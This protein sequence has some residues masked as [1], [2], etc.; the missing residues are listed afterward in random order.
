MYYNGEWGTVCDD[1]WDLNDAQVVCNELDLG[2]ATA[3]I[4]SAFYGHGSGQVWIDDLDC[5][6][7]E[8]TIRNCTHRGWGI[9]DCSHYEDASVNCTVG[10]CAG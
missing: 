8:E 6:G 2:K 9:E 5:A 7:T 1:F 10:K 4:Y 3:A